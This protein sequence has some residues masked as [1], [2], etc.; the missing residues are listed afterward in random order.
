MK[1]DVG[2]SGNS[3][4]QTTTKIVTGMGNEGHG[5]G[6][7]VEDINYDGQK[8]L[9]LM[10]YDDGSSAN[11]FRY[12]V[13]YSLDANGDVAYW[14]QNYIINGVG[15]MGDGAGIALYD[16]DQNGAKDMVLMG[17][18][19]PS[20]GNTFRYIIGWNLNGNGLAM[21]W[22]PTVIVNGVG[23]HGQGAGIDIRDIDNNGFLNSS[24]WHM[25]MHPV[26]IVSNTASFIT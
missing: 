10:A 5:A 14:S 17:Y 25:T 19:D 18:D 23:D 4:T 12:R 2:A 15:N 13:G 3:S 9:I 11:S 21:S 24:S 20:G 8:D 7:A 22:S 16:I 26:S 6:F 1:L